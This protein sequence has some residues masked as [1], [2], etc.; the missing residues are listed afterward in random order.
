MTKAEVQL[1]AL[2]LSERERLQLAAELWASIAN[3]NAYPD[4]LPLPQWQKDLLDERLDETKN[5]PGKPW[6]QV[7]AETWPSHS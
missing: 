6:D 3:P 2:Q 5:D 7:K 4:D 1:Q